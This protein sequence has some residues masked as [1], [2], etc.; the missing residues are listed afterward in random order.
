MGKQDF[1][2]SGMLKLIF[3]SLLFYRK[4]AVYQI[5]ITILLSSIITG[6]LF[7]GHSVRSS[8]KKTSEEKLGNTDIIL[9]SGL[10]YFD[11]SLSERVS[12]SSG[13]R[14]T[15]ILETD[16]Y[17]SNFSTGVTALNVKIYGITE[18]FFPFHAV[19]QV[20]INSGEAVI[21]SALALHLD[22]NEGEEIIIRFREADPLPA[23]APFAPSKDENGSKVMKVTRILS[24]SQAGNFS[25]GVSQQIPMTI[26]LNIADLGSAGDSVQKANRIIV[27]RE[28]EASYS[29]VLA[30]VLT[31]GDI[32]LTVRRSSKTGEPE[33]I[34]DRIFLDNLLV[35]DILKKIP[36]GKPVLT[37][38]VN[39]FRVNDR[40]TPYSFVSALPPGLYPGIDI[41]AIV[42]NKWLAEDLDA[43]TGETLTLTWYDPSF[44]RKLEEKQKDFYISAITENNSLYSDPA[45]MPDFPGI[46]GSA[47]CSGWDAGVPILMDQIRDKDEAYWNTFRGTPKAF[48][49][50]EAG[51]M[52]W[53]NNFGT[54]TAIRF[55]ASMTDSEIT[56]ALAGSLN[57]ETIGFTVT[58]VRQS[59]NKGAEESVDFSSLFLSLSFFMI[60]SCIIL[61][62]LALSMYFDSRKN[63][64]GVLFALGFRNNYIRKLLFTETFFLSAAGAIPGLFLGYLVN[65]IIIRALNSVWTGAVQTS[66]LTSDF[67]VIPM[68]YGFLIVLVLAAALILYKS[69]TFLKNLSRPAAGEL[70]KHS[71]RKNLLVFLIFWTI[72][73]IL[74]ISAFIIPQNST[75]LFFVSGTLLFAALVLLIRYS[76]VK[77][78]LE[79]SA[80]DNMKSN[81]RRKYYAFHP[82]HIVTPVI[83]IAAGI[84]AVMITGANRMVLT[85][86]MLLPPGGTGGYLL[87]AESAVPVKTDL[88]SPEGRKEF[89]LDE[90]ELKDLEI[91]QSDRV[92]GDDA[93]CLNLNKV[94][95][96]PLLGI[97]A[98]A[99]I[100]RGSF[101]FASQIKK[102]GNV[103]PWELLEENPGQ[104]SIYGIA[105]QTVLQWGLKIKTGDTLIFRAEN[106]QNLNIIICA[107]L[108]SSVFQGYLLISRENLSM[109]F[110]SVEGA[111]VFLIDGRSELSEVYRNTL[112]ERLS[113]YGF[114][115][116]EAGEKLASFFQVTNTYLNVFAVLGAFGMILGIAGLGFVLLRNYNIRRREFAFL[117]ATG[118]SETAIR[119]LILKDQMIILF[120]GVITGTVSGLTAT[121]PSVMSG[122]EMPWGIILIMILS[123]ISAGSAVLY[124][125]VRGIRSATLISQLRKE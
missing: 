114:S 43:K 53:G 25:P 91:M 47:T 112:N 29:D 103:N 9:S 119:K 105:D 54:A 102:S 32:G 98:S 62:L 20:L 8:L 58:D 66:S 84:F 61:F 120:W 90:E 31:P 87:W 64:T 17:C 52:L 45:L 80:F 123:I 82:S 85:D 24:A 6:S 7:T 95:S 36:S 11:A 92:S 81:I 122:N 18:G 71:P 78:V 10:R 50:Y 68:V 74:L 12:E 100:E 107:G 57:V 118:F 14:S 79:S 48:I 34:S 46:S 88:N 60:L 59:A 125:T 109:F 13:D 104:N 86:K 30:R 39:D 44:N 101:S 1:H 33:L 26:F 41:D 16:G 42:I 38:L 2:K 28:S 117:S 3:K 73:I 77:E 121:V 22:I 96:P 27:K 99:F 40:S 67:S 65:M 72:S 56:E 70:K 94:S 113:G 93:S 63:Q 21:N 106:G 124:L 23:N 110:P 51:K 83:F 37:Y 15:S 108:K 55:P 111:S 5:I 76:Y 69:G 115:S 97:D 89:G 4:D 75:P 35:S 116:Q 49:S 19:D